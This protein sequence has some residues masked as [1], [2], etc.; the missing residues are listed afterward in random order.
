MKSSANPKVKEL[1]EQKDSLERN[2]RVAQSDP[3]LLAGEQKIRSQ[4]GHVSE[5]LQ[6]KTITSNM[7][8][9]LLPLGRYKKSSLSI[10]LVEFIEYQTFNADDGF[11]LDGEKYGA[12]IL[13]PNTKSDSNDSNTQPVRIFFGNEKDIKKILLNY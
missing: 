10:L 3:K 6:R 11:L 5:R 12:V 8:L 2:L 13:F 7:R 4:L 1:L 9:L